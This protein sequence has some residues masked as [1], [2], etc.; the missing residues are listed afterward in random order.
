MQ[1]IDYYKNEYRATG[2]VTI[3]GFVS[4]EILDGAQ[5]ELD[6]YKWW[7]YA[8]RPHNNIRE[9]AYL[10]E[11]SEDAY[12]ECIHSL[13]NNLFCYHFK[14][15]YGV[16]YDTCICISCRLEQYAKSES[17]METI[18][19]IVDCS[20]IVPNEIFV[21]N[22]SKDDFLSIHHDIGKGDI[23]ATF[24]LTEEWNPAWGG[25]LHF[26][27]ASNNIYKSISPQFGSLHLFRLDSEAGL[28]HFVSAVSVN[29][30][31]YTLTAWYN[32]DK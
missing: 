17:V 2:I 9:T 14:R 11:Y 18:C 16:H 31:R 12:N 10:P 6:N 19:Q 3:P 7:V 25:V 27:D 1:S 8:A 22:Y 30:N 29:K 24:S 32:V 13:E 21:S 4:N 23:S 28:D 15:S 5:D 26:C 20:K